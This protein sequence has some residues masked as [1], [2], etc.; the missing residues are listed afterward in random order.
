MQAHT[1]A[2]DDTRYRDS[3]DV[4]AWID[5]DPLTRMHEFLSAKKWLT[6][7]AEHEMTAESEALA[8]ELRVVR[9]QRGRS[10]PPRTCSAMSTPSAPRRCRSSGSRSRMS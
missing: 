6:Q 9:E 1:N 7:A 4:K 5:R 8:A 3:D 2:D 10:R